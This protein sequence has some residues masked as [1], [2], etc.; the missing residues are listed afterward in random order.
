MKYFSPGFVHLP[1]DALPLRQLHRH[2]WEVRIV[3]QV[4]V[5]PPGGH[6]PRA[7][8]QDRDL[9]V[10]Q[11]VDPPRLHW[12][13]QCLLQGCHQSSRLSHC[14][15]KVS[16][17]KWYKCFRYLLTSSFSRRSDG[18]FIDDRSI[19][20]IG[21]YDFVNGPE[22]SLALSSLAP[23]CNS[24]LPIS[25]DHIRQVPIQKNLSRTK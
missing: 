22:A 4:R 13:H 1:P 10:R 2:C 21:N 17:D 12:V 9:G 5:H 8:D 18:F 16:W 15:W 14:I 19:G 23:G 3:R 7:L 6:Q 24:T 25:A 20:D 11:W